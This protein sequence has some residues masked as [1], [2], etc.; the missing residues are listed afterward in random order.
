VKTQW[1]GKQ[2]ISLPGDKFTPG[3]K[4]HPWG[5]TSP[6][7]SKFVQRGKVKN[8]PQRLAIIQLHNCDFK[9]FMNKINEFN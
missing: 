3:N 4:I 9:K 1:R 5:I 7:G 6:L 8:G 2:R